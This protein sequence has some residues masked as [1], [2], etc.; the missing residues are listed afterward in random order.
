MS[1]CIRCG[2]KTEVTYKFCMSCGYPV[3]SNP[4]HASSNN[5][6]SNFIIPNQPVCIQCGSTIDSTDKFCML[7]GYPTQ[8]Q[9]HRKL[10]NNNPKNQ[11]SQQNC[12]K[13]ECIDELTRILGHFSKVQPTYDNYDNNLRIRAEKA[14]EYNSSNDPDD[15]YNKI[16][17]FLYA[18]GFTLTVMGFVFWASS[19]EFIKQWGWFV[20]GNIAGSI[21]VFLSVVKA[22]Y[23]RRLRREIIECDTARASLATELTK[24][25]ANYGYCIIGPEYTNPKILDKIIGNLRYGRANT[26]NDAIK[27]LYHDIH[28]REFRAKQL[29]IEEIK[30]ND[31]HGAKTAAAYI[32]AYFFLEKD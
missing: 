21:G 32:P 5:A 29:L 26:L 24:H 9:T 27:I 6:T 14:G 15:L 22:R 4:Q 31:S 25:Y 13:E 19:G 8:Q 1:V 20:S 12:S 11:A 17:L 10:K 30:N 23:M 16:Y 3:Q 18:L 2:T 28:K 7:C